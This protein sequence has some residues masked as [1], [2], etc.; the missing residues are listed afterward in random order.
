[1]SDDTYTPDETDLFI[2]RLTN[3][4][5]ALTKERDELRAQVARLRGVLQD[6]FDTPWVGSDPDH[7]NEVTRVK[8]SIQATLQ[9]TPHDA[10]QYVRVLEDALQ[11]VV[12]F[13]Y[14]GD[15]GK[16]LDLERVEKALAAKEDRE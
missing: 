16:T 8:R 6:A 2:E 12:D 11:Y 14:E 1:M 3:K 7:V 13:Y 5:N 15:L 10:A 4:C 9:E